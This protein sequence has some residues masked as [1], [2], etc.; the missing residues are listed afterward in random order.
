MITVR[1][2][3]ELER[4]IEITAKQ[5]GITK[6]E[7]IRRSL[8]EYLKKIRAETTPWELGKDLFGKYSSGK[9][10]LSKD[11]KK[12]LRQKLLEKHFEKTID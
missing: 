6:S 3:P 2:E 9:R 4:L 5:F 11:R 12:I 1:L 8:R 7:V 10:N